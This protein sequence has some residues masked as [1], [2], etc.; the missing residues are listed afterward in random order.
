MFESKDS[1]RVGLVAASAAG[2]F[3]FENLCPSSHIMAS[4]ATV[5]VSKRVF[6]YNIP[7]FSNPRMTGQS[8]AA[9]AACCVSRL[10]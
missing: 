8:Q 2:E 1:H 7:P 4:E 5:I 3:H 10:A 6:L 9:P